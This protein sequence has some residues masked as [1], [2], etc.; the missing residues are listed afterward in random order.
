M[1]STAHTHT[2]AAGRP[3]AGPVRPLTAPGEPAPPQDP[4]RSLDDRWPTTVQ[5]WN[6]VESAVL[7]GYGPPPSSFL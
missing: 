6:W 2:P 7:A 5:V 1:T 3:A 4:A